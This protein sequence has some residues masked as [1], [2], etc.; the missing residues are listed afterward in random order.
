MA[1]GGG[2]LEL[3]ILGAAIPL[4]QRVCVALARA[5]DRLSAARLAAEAHPSR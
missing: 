1:E 4:R 2:D 5:F 3:P